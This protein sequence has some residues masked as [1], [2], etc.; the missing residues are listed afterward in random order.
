MLLFVSFQIAHSQTP[1][2]DFFIDTF[3]KNISRGDSVAIKFTALI[4]PYSTEDFVIRVIPPEGPS[5]QYVLR[6]SA[7]ALGFASGISHYP[8]DFV[9]ASTQ[10]IGNYSIFIQESK[11]RAIVRS[12]FFQV[13][14]PVEAKSNPP[15]LL[16]TLLIPGVLAAVGGGLTYLY[17]ILSSKKERTATLYEKKTEQFLSSSSVY[18]HIVGWARGLARELNKATNDRDPLKCLL[19]LYPVSSTT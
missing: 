13:A 17:N 3:P 16:T 9:N 1:M 6:L 10:H 15:D 2:S 11:S 14:L 7:D 4:L 19:F 18:W 8:S 12:S 5:N